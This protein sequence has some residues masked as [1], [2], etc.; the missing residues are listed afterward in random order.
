MAD[1]VRALGEIGDA[2]WAVDRDDARAV[3]VRSFQEIDKLS[4]GSERD[5]ER[6]ANQIRFLRRTVLSRI[7][8]HDPALANQLIHDLPRDPAT[9][10]QKQMQ[11]EGVA[12][13]NGEA[14]LGIAENLLVS[15]SKRSVALAGYS[16]QEGLSQRLRLFLIELRSKE[17]AAADALVEA[18]LQQAATQHPGRLFDVML[19]WDYVYQPP[20]F[21]LNGIVWDREKSEPRYQPSPVLK[22][23]VLTFAVTAVIENLQ[24]FGGTADSDQDKRFAQ[25]HT[26]AL[27]SVIKQLLPS[28]QVDFPQGATDLQQALARVAQELQATG[29]T[30]PDRPEI[31]DESASAT[32]LLDKLLEKAGAASPGEARDCLYLGAAFKLLQLGEYERAKEIAAKI[33]G[34]EQRAMLVEPLNFYR[35]GELIEKGNLNEALSIA[36]QLKRPDLR[37]NTFASLA[38]SFIEKGKLQEALEALTEGKISAGKAEPTIEVSAATLRLAS[39]L[40][41]DDPVQ[42]SEVVVLAIQIANKT[43]DE[44]LWPLLSPP[45]SP[46]TLTFTWTNAPTG[47]LK[48]VKASSARNGGL[49]ELLSKLEFDRA[50]SLARELKSKGVSLAAQAAVCRA[51]IEFTEPKIAAGQAR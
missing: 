2:L 46:N 23:A 28:M 43:T 48:S 50:V 9:A 39:A 3:L 16:L 25:A 34:L 42:A 31:K 22:R 49:A 15:D 45:A 13:P 26:A 51:A 24:L 37:I 20:D 5:R 12:A 47:G 41:K 17:P 36:Y 11:L 18:A 4:P 1:R 40:T 35:A 30:L 14:L 27:Y 44:N 8:R 7:A 10:E 19:L 38:R 6:I 21:Y 32:T 29:Q 33:D